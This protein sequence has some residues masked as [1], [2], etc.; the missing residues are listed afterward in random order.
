MKIWNTLFQPS[1]S[2]PSHFIAENRHLLSYCPGM[3]RES[4]EAN[5]LPGQDTAVLEYTISGKRNARFGWEIKLG[6][7]WGTEGAVR[8]VRWRWFWQWL[9][10]PKNVPQMRAHALVPLLKSSCQ[11][12]K[13]ST[14]RTK[15]SNILDSAGEILLTAWRWVSQARPTLPLFTSLSTCRPTLVQVTSVQSLP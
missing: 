9:S 11:T 4:R 2:A 5:F 13:Y 8:S 3:W 1:P 15:A 10:D 7:E 6:L 12:G 14:H